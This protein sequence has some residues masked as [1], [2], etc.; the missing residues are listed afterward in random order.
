M[1]TIYGTFYDTT[2]LKNLIPVVHN[3]IM[4]NVLIV[5]EVRRFKADLEECFFILYLNL[6]NHTRTL[7]SKRYP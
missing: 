5:L 3:N 6:P 7:P 2:E 4:Q 1:K